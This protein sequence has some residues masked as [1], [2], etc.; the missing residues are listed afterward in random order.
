[1]GVLVAGGTGA[2][3]RAVVASCSTSGYDCAL[4]WV[5]EG[6][7]RRA[8]QEFGE[9]ADADPRR[10]ARPG[11]GGGAVA[12]VDELEAVVNLVGGFATG[13]RV[14]ET[15]PSEFARML[16]LNLT[17]AFN[18]ARAGMPRMIERG[19]GA[20]VGVSAQSALKP[21]AGAAG[22]ITAKSAVLAFI[23]AL[24]AEYKRRR[25]PLQ[26]DPAERD[27]HAGEP[28]RRARRGPLEVGAAGGDREGRPLPR[29][30]RVGAHDGRRD[31]GLAS[32]PYQSFG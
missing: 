14:H 31:P 28:R 17:P 30:G 4:T 24:D 26:R 5:V 25:H 6:E 18:L 29:V 8:E 23:R 15:D 10:P 1:M 13:G 16:E 19:G 12:E 27:R 3:G 20:F 32:L 11:G 7:R 2:L 22:Y 9:R 21:F